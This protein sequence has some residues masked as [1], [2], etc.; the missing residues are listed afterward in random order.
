M[1]TL[2][3]AALTAVGILLGVS[4][5]IGGTAAAKGQKKEL[6][7]RE[8]FTP[9]D[10]LKGQ[11]Y[12]NAAMAA[13]MMD[14]LQKA[15]VQHPDIMLEYGI[16]LDLGRPSVSSQMSKDDRDKL[17]RGFRDMLDL[18]ITK[19]DKFDITFNED[20]MLD[21]SEFWIYLAKHVGRPKSRASLAGV[22]QAESAPGAP[23]MAFVPD[24][25]NQDKEFN[26][27][28]DLILKPNVVNAATACGQSAY[29]FARMHKVQTVDIAE[30]KL[31]PEQ[32]ATAQEAAV[33]AYRLSY[34]EGVLACGDREYFMRVADFASRNL[35]ALGN[36]K[37]SPTAVVA[38]VG[39]A[40]VEE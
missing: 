27:N 25:P 20:A 33:K 21:Q 19:S 28:E 15:D 38:D 1:K 16:A 34:A 7:N 35:G 5:A 8:S 12:V 32:F 14:L 31:T 9:A 3:G 13:P 22:A 4:L 39:M 6:S 23:P 2:R 11:A 30:T 40:K 24:D 37:D 36:M 26:L 17:K 29:G 18:Y 10:A